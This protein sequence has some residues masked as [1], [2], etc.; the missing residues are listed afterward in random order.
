MNISSLSLPVIFAILGGLLLL[1]SLAQLPTPWGQFGITSGRP[2]AVAAV[3]GVALVTVAVYVYLHQPDPSS[4][5]AAPNPVPSLSDKE[6]TPPKSSPVDTRPSLALLTKNS[7]RWS[8][9]AP[10]P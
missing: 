7:I 6:P 3:A 2:R 8:E 1:S 9:T 10:E 5:A 4:T